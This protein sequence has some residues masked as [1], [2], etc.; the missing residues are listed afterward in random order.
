[1]FGHGAESFRA[2]NGITSHSTPIDLLYNFGLVGLALFY[3][4]FASLL[5]RLTGKV[6]ARSQSLR[7]LVLAGVVCQVF[8]SLSGTLYYQSFLALFVGTSTALL[9]RVSVQRID[10]ALPSE[11]AA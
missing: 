8:M 3:A 2:E 4:V 5:W 9:R 11:I 6:D 10:R 7:A 1:M